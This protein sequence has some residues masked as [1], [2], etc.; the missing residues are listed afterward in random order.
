MQVLS[1]CL[2][3]IPAND[4]TSIALEPTLQELISDGLK[5][6]KL[7]DYQERLGV[8]QDAKLYLQ[9]F[10]KSILSGSKGH[11]RADRSWLEDEEGEPV[12]GGEDG[13]ELTWTED[14][15]FQPMSPALTIRAIRQTPKL[16]GRLASELIPGPAA[17]L[18]RS[19]SIKEVDTTS[20]DLELSRKE[21]LDKNMSESLC[22]CINS[23]IIPSLILSYTEAT[24][25]SLTPRHYRL[26]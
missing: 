16:R 15:I 25:S 18:L 22:V 7:Q 5:L 19:H 24:S 26:W 12:F 10:F 3:I 14:V 13:N 17:S 4:P 9:G 1:E 2:Y 6:S 11:S 21:Q 8:D 20:L 23:E